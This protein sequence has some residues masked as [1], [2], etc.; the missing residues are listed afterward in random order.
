MNERQFSDSRNL[1][2]LEIAHIQVPGVAQDLKRYLVNH[3]RQVVSIEHPFKSSAAFLGS[4]GSRIG[5]FVEKKLSYHKSLPSIAGP[6]IFFWIRDFWITQI[7]VLTRK[8]RFDAVICLDCLNALSGIMLKVLGKSRYIVYYTIDL[9]DKRFSFGLLNYL[10]LL[11]DKIAVRYADEVWDV[12]QSI[13]EL[14]KMHGY[15]PKTNKVKIVPIG[16]YK[17]DFR[18]I[19]KVRRDPYRLIYLGSLFRIMGIQLVI[20]S[21]PRLA[22]KYPKITLYIIGN[23]DY[24]PELRKRIAELNVSRY[25]RFYPYTDRGKIVPLLYSGWVG[26]APYLDE[27]GSYKKYSDPTKIKEYF[28]TGLP[29][30]VT[31]VP[32]IS[33][34]ISQTRLGLTIPYD[35]QAFIDAASTLI[36]NRSFH[37]ACVRNVERFVTEYEWEAIFSRAFEDISGPGD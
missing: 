2:I 35:L 26:V 31:D 33:K 6:E 18:N 13:S 25:V 30:I 8:Y 10:Y 1:R 23:G 22:A 19:R 34:R 12:S 17:S 11:L 5:E 14:R 4:N 32:I 9:T 21:L 7:W 36:E 15:N 3:Y 16:Y 20:E 37:D 27:E 24:L 28:A 29:V